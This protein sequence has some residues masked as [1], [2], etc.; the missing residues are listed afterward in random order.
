MAWEGS[1]RKSRLP[2]NWAKLRAAQL[3]KDA[4]TCQECGKSKEKYPDLRLEVDHI[5]AMKDDHS[6]LQT[7]CHE[8]HLAKSSA[9]GGK[10][11]W[12]AIKK[13][14]SKFRHN[15]EKHPGYLV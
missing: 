6:R 11:Y 15:S 14:R 4:Y 12:A 7:L 10:A 2:G 9:E 1:T 13:S 3:R 5:E 8:C